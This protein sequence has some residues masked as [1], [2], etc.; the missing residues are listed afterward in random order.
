MYVLS[1][2]FRPIK[3]RA[4]IWIIDPSIRCLE[5]LSILNG[6]VEP[7]PNAQLGYTYH[8]VGDVVTYICD[9]GYTLIGGSRTC[10]ENENTDLRPEWSGVSTAIACIPDDEIGLLDSNSFI[11]AFSQLPISFMCS[12][13]ASNVIL[14][15]INNVF[16]IFSVAS[17]W[18]KRIF[19]E[20]YCPY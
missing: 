10:Q 9:A 1:Q 17:F 14:T 7:P 20:W 19:F 11:L 16:L 2:C 8:V 4:S 12:H 18:R 3:L 13:L 6:R 5:R 15:S